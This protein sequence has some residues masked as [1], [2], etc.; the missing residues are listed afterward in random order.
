MVWTSATLC[1]YNSNEY[2]TASGSRFNYAAEAAAKSG[3]FVG[4]RRASKRQT[5]R[6]L[7]RLRRA[8][9]VDFPPADK[10]PA[11]AAAVL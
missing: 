6:Q 10:W 2:L 7:R 1:R 4:R 9:S 8:A 11:I 5:R 3:N